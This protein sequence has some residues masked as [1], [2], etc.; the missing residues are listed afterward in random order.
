MNIYL[1]IQEFLKR[2]D[3]RTVGQLA[4]DVNGRAIDDSEGGILQ[5][6]IDDGASEL[7]SHLN[8]NYS[9]LVNSPAG[10]FDIPF[11]LKRWVAAV[12]VN[13]TYARRSDMPQKVKNDVTWAE[14]WIEKLDLRKI[15]LPKLT[16]SPKPVL[17]FSES[18]QGKS[19]F[20]P[21]AADFDRAPSPTATD[22][23]DLPQTVGDC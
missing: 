20:D 18:K 23:Q 3:A 6:L 7:D 15:S 19:R 10:T 5:T 17:Q 16:R 9:S 14:S 12:A 4:N 2:Y 8:M 13:H 11:V 1:T 21:G 22:G